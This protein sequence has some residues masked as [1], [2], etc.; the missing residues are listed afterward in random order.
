MLL[1]ADCPQ[2]YEV[3]EHFSHLKNKEKSQMIE[4]EENTACVHGRLINAHTGK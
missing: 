2:A 3:G 4:K 1:A